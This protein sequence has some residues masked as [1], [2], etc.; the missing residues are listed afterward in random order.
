[1]CDWWVW[2]LGGCKSLF[3]APGLFTKAVP[4]E[5]CIREAAKECL[6]VFFVCISVLTGL[7]FPWFASFL[8]VFFL[9]SGCAGGVCGLAKEQELFFV[10][11]PDLDQ[12]YIWCTYFAMYN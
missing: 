7:L 9:S 5:L 12:R 4:R 6:P 8:D 11:F 1:M 3:C 10:F 2:P